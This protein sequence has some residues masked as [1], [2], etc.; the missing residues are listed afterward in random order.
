MDGDDAILLAL[1]L[2]KERAILGYG[3][4]AWWFPKSMDAEGV[5]LEW[6]IVALRTRRGIPG[7][8]MCWMKPFPEG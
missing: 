7:R 8:L 6:S 4:T 5:G 2:R 3:L 1:T